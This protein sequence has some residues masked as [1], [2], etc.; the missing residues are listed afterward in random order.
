MSMHPGK[1]TDDE[2]DAAAE[3]FYADP[4]Q[5]SAARLTEVV[6]T[7]YKAVRD[8]ISRQASRTARHHLLAS[9]D[10]VLAHVET[11]Q[12]QRDAALAALNSISTHYERLARRH[13]EDAEAVLRLDAALHPDTGRAKEQS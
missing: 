1:P 8:F 7:N 13:P 5:A 11:L 3:A 9:L 6:L 12:Q 2:Q 10:A 4:T